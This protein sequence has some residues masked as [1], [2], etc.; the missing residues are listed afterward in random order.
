MAIL[1]DTYDGLTLGRESNHSTTHYLNSYVIVLY[2]EKYLVAFR[3]TF[4][5]RD[6]SD[7]I[8]CIL[9]TKLNATLRPRLVFLL[10][11]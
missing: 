9:L 1:L 5:I 11:V 2:I 3:V 4:S 6:I 8:F 10:S 7:L